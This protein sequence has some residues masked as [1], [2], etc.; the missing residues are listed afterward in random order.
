MISELL[1]MMQK[2]KR[3]QLLRWV[4][5]NKKEATSLEIKE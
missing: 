5:G 2:N 1:Y 3:K 4:Y